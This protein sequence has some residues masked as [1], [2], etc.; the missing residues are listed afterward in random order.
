MFWHKINFLVESFESPGLI[1]FKVD[2][3][4]HYSLL[5]VRKNF[6]LAL[7]TVITYHPM[8]DMEAIPR[9]TW[10]KASYNQKKK[11]LT[12]IDIYNYIMIDSKSYAW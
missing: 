9:R 11:F 4:N 5:I 12:L 1:S 6:S 8:S 7:F 10:I 3:P 2:F